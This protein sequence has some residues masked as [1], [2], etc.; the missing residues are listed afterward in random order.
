[1]SKSAVK[2]AV[3]PAALY[4]VSDIPRDGEPYVLEPAKARVPVVLKTVEVDIHNGWSAET[5]ESVTVWRCIG[6]TDGGIKG[7]APEICKFSIVRTPSGDDKLLDPPKFTP[8]S[9]QALAYLA[10]R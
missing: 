4:V 3:D 9:E 5:G 10:S 1:M 8:L 7:H 6:L 2:S